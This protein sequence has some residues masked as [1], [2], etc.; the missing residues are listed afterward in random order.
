M[1]HPSPNKRSSILLS[2]KRLLCVVLMHETFRI[3]EPYLNE[4]GIELAVAPFDAVYVNGVLTVAIRYAIKGVI[5]GHLCVTEQQ[6][7]ITGMPAGTTLD[8]HDPNSLPALVKIMQTLTDPEYL[9]VL[10][11]RPSK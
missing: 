11:M 8:L 7:S 6:I 3:I 2:K 5:H 10:C 4:N 9:H 1:G